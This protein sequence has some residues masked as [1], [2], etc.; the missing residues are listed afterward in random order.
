MGCDSRLP[1]GSMLILRVDEL[2]AAAA[3]STACPAARRPAPCHRA[4][5][6]RSTSPAPAAPMCFTACRRE[7]ALWSEI[8]FSRFGFLIASSRRGGGVWA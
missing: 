4:G 3:I 2:T 8:A 5:G 1:S 6:P 7:M